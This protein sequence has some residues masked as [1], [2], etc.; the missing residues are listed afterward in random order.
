MCE[1]MTMSWNSPWC[2]IDLGHLVR[3]HGKTYKVTKCE[4]VADRL[5]EIELTLRKRRK[6]CTNQ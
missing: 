4:H 2:R 1:K 3:Y 5:A 6:K